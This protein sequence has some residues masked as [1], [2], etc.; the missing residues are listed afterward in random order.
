MIAFGESADPGAPAPLISVKYVQSSATMR[1]SRSNWRGI[2]S[3]LEGFHAEPAH[4]VEKSFVR[5]ALFD[6]HVQ[7][8]RDRFRHVGLRHGWAD[9]R[10]QGRIGPGRAADGDLVPLL[11][12]LIH[13]ENADVPHVVVTAGVHA[14]RH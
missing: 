4:G 5:S 11:T 10:A 12:A 2:H 13:A 6:I 3:L 1:P 9:H 7:Q 14:P 8:P